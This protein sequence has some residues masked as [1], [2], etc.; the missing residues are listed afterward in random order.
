MFD[1]ERFEKTRL[2]FSY[3]SILHTISGWIDETQ[4]S[5]VTARS[6]M[7]RL[8]GLHGAS[9]NV[10]E[11]TE[12]ADILD[13]L[14]KRQSDYVSVLLARV[15]SLESEIEVLQDG[16]SFPDPFSYCRFSY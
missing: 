11:A 12:V 9:R 3:L 15:K 10:D 6:H 13:G 16:V 14:L 1:D 2:F 8:L 4:S 7:R 5:L